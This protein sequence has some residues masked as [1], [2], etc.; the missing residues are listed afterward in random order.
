MSQCTQFLK[1][2]R[3]RLD[4]PCHVNLYLCYSIFKIKC[5][6]STNFHVLTEK[7]LFRILFPNLLL[8]EQFL[9]LS[10]YLRYLISVYLV[11]ESRTLTIV[12]STNIQS[13]R[14]DIR[15]PISTYPF[16]KWSSAK[17]TVTKLPEEGMCVPWVQNG[18]VQYTVLIN[19]GYRY[20]AP[21]EHTC[22]HREVS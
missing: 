13:W 18:E 14:L 5:H 17:Y 7:Y 1:K 6:N 11:F 2:I 19:R 9:Y 21:R 10:S 3:T 22:P 20:F 15:R 4:V 12:N 16:P 8:L